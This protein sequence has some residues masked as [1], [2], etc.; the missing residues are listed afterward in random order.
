L[1]FRSGLS[2]NP[3]GQYSFEYQSVSLK[4]CLGEATEQELEPNFFDAIYQ[5]AFSPDA[6]PELW[7]ETFFR[8]LYNSLKHNGYLTTYSVK[9]DVRRTLQSLGFGVHKRPGPVG[10]KREMLVAKKLENGKI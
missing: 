4:L 5:D 9:G 3:V 10:G 7:T 1:E 8:K 2:E 6:N